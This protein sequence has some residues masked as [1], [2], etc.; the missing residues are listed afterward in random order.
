MDIPGSFQ[1]GFGPIDIHYSSTFRH[2]ATSV[3]RVSCSYFAF[4]HAQ[5]IDILTAACISK[6][7]QSSVRTGS[8]Q[9]D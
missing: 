2:R 9:I 5:K 6:A 1:G 4:R 7:R 3:V 8:G